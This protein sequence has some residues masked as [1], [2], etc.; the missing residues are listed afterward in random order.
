MAGLYGFGEGKHK[1]EAAPLAIV[2]CYAASERDY[3]VLDDW[4]T[5][6]GASGLARTAGI[7]AEEAVKQ[8]GQITVFDTYAVV[9]EREC[10]ETV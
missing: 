3:G 5:Q 9:V 10:V 7:D 8:M 2:D 6:T 1:F 4:Q